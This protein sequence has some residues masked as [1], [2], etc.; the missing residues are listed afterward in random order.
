MDRVVALAQDPSAADNVATLVQSMAYL[1]GWEEKNFQ[2]S[3]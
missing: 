1:P 2:V 3:W